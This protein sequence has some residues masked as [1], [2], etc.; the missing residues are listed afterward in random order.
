MSKTN[1]LLFLGETYRAD[2]ISWINGIENASQIEIQ[3]LELH[4]FKY[5]VIRIFQILLLIFRFLFRSIYSNKYDIVL[6]ERSTSYGFISLFLR[7]K[8]RVVAQQ[9]ISDIYP[10][11]GFSKIYKSQ[12]QKIVYKRADLVHAWGNAMTYAQL[13]SGASPLKIIV[14]PKGLDLSKYIFFN[15]FQDQTIKPL[16]IVTR[17]L[18]P[19]YRHADIIRAVSILKEKGFELTVWIIGDGYLMEELKEYAIELNVKSLIDFKGRIDNEVLPSLITQC[20]IYIS[21]PITEGV[22]SSLFE[23]MACGCIPIVTKLPGNKAFINPGINGE[24]VT[25]SSPESLAQKLIQV[26]KNPSLYK[27]GVFENRRFIDEHANRD[28][29]MAYFYGRYTELIEKN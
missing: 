3:T 18:L 12:L 24:L 19:D 29:N 17:S 9:G 1:K 14:R 5:R 22:S 16:A 7:A 25:V 4:N 11:R 21:T 8:V 15:H 6:A 27:L 2:A 23:A 13:K 10:N 20:P 28:V 26:L